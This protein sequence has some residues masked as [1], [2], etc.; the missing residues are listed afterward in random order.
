MQEVGKG[1]CSLFVTLGMAA[2]AG[3]RRGAET[4]WSWGLSPT[5]GRALEVMQP[6]KVI[7]A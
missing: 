7:V 2:L 4:A 1:V 6:G 5:L 3:E